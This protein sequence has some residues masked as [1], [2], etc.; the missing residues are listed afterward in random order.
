MVMK[1][2]ADLWHG[3]KWTE[4]KYQLAPLILWCVAF[5]EAVGTG[6]GGG[7]SSTSAQQTFC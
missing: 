3:S 2:L 7:G 4:N 6:G 1:V 5:P